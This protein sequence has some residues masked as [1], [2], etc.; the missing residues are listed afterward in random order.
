MVFNNRKGVMSKR[1]ALRG[2]K[3]LMH[4][5]NKVIQS[6][7]GKEFAVNIQ[8]TTKKE[9]HNLMPEIPYVGGKKFLQ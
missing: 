1:T 3:G 4:A 9:L 5:A 8:K 6:R 2:A 7:F